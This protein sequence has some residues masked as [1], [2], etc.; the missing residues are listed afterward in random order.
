[1]KVIAGF[2]FGCV[3]FFKL[4]TSAVFGKYEAGQETHSTN[5]LQISADIYLTTELDC[6][7]QCSTIK[8]KIVLHQIWILFKN[9][10]HKKRQPFPIGLDASLVTSTPSSARFP[11]SHLSALTSDASPGII[12]SP[13]CF[14]LLLPWFCHT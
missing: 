14:L 11:F 12:W 5:L 9:K 6:V 13:P 4:R 3:F 8:F 2:A 10:P 1:M 7:Y